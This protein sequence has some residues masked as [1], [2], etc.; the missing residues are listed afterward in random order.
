MAILNLRLLVIHI[1]IENEVP[2]TAKKVA[3]DSYSP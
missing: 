1:N 3:N 2:L